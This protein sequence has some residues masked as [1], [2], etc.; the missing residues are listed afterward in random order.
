MVDFMQQHAAPPVIVPAPSLQTKSMQTTKLIVATGVI[1]LFS[2]AALVSAAEPAAA[3]AEDRPLH[4]VPW[5]TQITIAKTRLKPGANLAF[6]TDNKPPAMRV[7]E[8]CKEDFQELGFTV[9]VGAKTPGGAA[10]AVRLQLADDA[11]LGEEGYRLQ[12]AKEVVLT[13]KTETGLFWGSRTLLQLLW[14][15]PDTEVPNVTISDRP[16]AGY[17]SLMIDNARRFHSLD[18]HLRM[19]RALALFK[20]NSYQIHFS[21]NEGYTLPTPGIR[22]AEGETGSYS[23]AD[24]KKLTDCAARYHVTLIPE[25]DMPGH[26]RSIK[27]KLPQTHCASADCDVDLCLGSEASLKAAEAIISDTLE[28]FPGPYYHLGADEVN[29]G[30]YSRCTACQQAMQ[31]A[32]LNGEAALYRSFINRM[33]KFVKSKGKRMIVWEGFDIASGEPF[34]DKDVIVMP[35]DSF[36]GKTAK[37][38]LAGGHEVINAAWTPLYVVDFKAAPPEMLA[39]WDLTRF[40]RFPCP[41][42]QEKWYQV[43]PTPKLLGAQMC[44]WANA[45][46]EAHGLLFGQ[47]PKI[48]DGTPAAR[49]PIFAERVWTAGKT[50]TQNIL[51]R[52]QPLLARP[53]LK[54][55]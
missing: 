30:H 48:R 51:Q 54:A 3:P 14:E 2:A 21:D 31:T 37:E 44:S 24:I 35:F 1:A 13:A 4:L 7:A 50:D 18:F 52:L 39:G 10:L 6:L 38:Y 29:F 32:K 26:A 45:E 28:M 22:P 25:I 55:K 5:P 11:T 23:R 36:A 46:T 40:G 27:A 16:A 47:E 20:L 34:V 8:G 15:G 12:V 9:A 43:E 33:N 42:P 17:R 49:L 19:I 41:E 53:L